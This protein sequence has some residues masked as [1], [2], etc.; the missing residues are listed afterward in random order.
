MEINR[1]LEILKTNIIRWYSFKENSNILLVGNNMNEI[2]DFLSQ[3][4]NV[5]MLDAD[6]T[7]TSNTK[8]DYIIVKDKISFLENFKENLVEDGSILLLMNNRWGVQFLAGADGFE[9]L[10]GNKNHLIDKVEIE[11][12]LNEKGFNNY[13]FFY[14]LPN[15]EFANTI[16]SDEYLPESTDSKLANN[17]V[18]LNDNYLVF[19]EIELLKSFTKNGEFTK[20]TNS[21]LIEINPKSTEKAIFFGNSRKEEYKVITKIYDGQ[22]EKVAFSEKSVSHIKQIQ[23]NVEDL[24]AHGFDLLD[25]VEDEKLISKYVSLPNMYEAT[26]NKI[27]NGDIQKATEIIE[28]IYNDIK[29]KFTED[30]VQEINQ[31]YFEGLDASKLFIVKKAYIDLVF[32]N[33][34]FDN[35][36]M[37]VYDQ[38]WVI[39]NCPVEFIL[40]RLINNM[41]LM[42]SE[43][44]EVI[45]RDEMLKKFGLLNYFDEFLKAESIFQ[46]KVINQDMI[47]IYNRAN[48]LSIS[49][50]EI[51]N[52]KENAYM[53]GLYKAENIKKEKYIESLQAEIQRLSQEINNK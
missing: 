43:I 32:E 20:F 13:R 6:V 15:Y 53:I 17:N 29:E 49:K 18:Y 36:G 8:F 35:Q 19:N 38:E 30:R 28:K 37:Y 42:N 3:K 2:C 14:P 25:R 44:S 31:E 34:F 9:T 46:N 4:H 50:E 12:Y 45:S 26:V 23:E 16:F 51:M 1:D 22:V 27:K 39:D 52:A 33:M 47:K 10:Y 40:F 11:K 48:E 5:K 21:Y 41:Y 24:K 7:Y